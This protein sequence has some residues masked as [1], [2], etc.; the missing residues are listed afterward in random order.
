MKGIAPRRE[1]RHIGS[2]ATRRANA[3]PPLTTTVCKETIMADLSLR[4]DSAQTT[5]LFPIDYPASRPA[6]A[7][8]RLLARKAEEWAAWGDPPPLLDTIIE[9]LDWY[10]GD[11]D[12]GCA[13]GDELEDEDAIEWVYWM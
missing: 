2:G 10:D 11:P 7:Q 6:T 4:A 13:N 9:L 5:P 8:Q 12:D 3:E 1:L